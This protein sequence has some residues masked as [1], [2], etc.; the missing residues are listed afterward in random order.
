MEVELSSPNS[1]VELVIEQ[2]SELV[3][4]DESGDRV[5]INSTSR[6]EEFFASKRNEPKH[7]PLS[8][9][10]TLNA[11]VNYFVVPFFQGAFYGLGE[12]VA[13]Y[14][15]STYIHPISPFFPTGSTVQRRRL[16]KRGTDAATSA[17]A[18]EP[19]PIV[20]ATTLEPSISLLCP[21]LQS[22]YQR[23]FSAR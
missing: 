9:F 19:A 8:A 4:I 13:R 10:F 5:E 12:L 6:V 1:S 11:F 7:L 15:F 3:K 18:K 14:L 22:C 17:A 23:V 2:D 16:F 20:L 21:I